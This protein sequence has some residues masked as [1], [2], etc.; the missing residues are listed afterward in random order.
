MM[1]FTPLPN[2]GQR[3]IV[4]TTVVHLSSPSVESI[5][6]SIQILSRPVLKN[7]AEKLFHIF[8]VDQP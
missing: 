8:Q 7:Y 4:V 6:P 2:F 3:G 1:I 5:H